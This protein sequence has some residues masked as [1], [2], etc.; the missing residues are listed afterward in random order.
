MSSLTSLT[1]WRTVMADPHWRQAEFGV[2]LITAARLRG[3]E[4]RRTE[5]CTKACNKIPWISTTVQWRSSNL[6][7]MVSIWICFDDLFEWILMRSFNCFCWPAWTLSHRQQTIVKKLPYLCHSARR[8]RKFH[9]IYG[10]RK[11]EAY[12]KGS[13]VKWVFDWLTDRTSDWLNEIEWV[14]GWN[15][16]WKIAWWITNHPRVSPVFSV[17]LLLLLLFLLLLLRCF[18]S[19]SYLFSDP[20]LLWATSSLSQILLAETFLW[21]TSSA[22]KCHAKC[23]SS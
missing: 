18:C 6:V 11:W 4:R 3:A 7:H 14:D 15:A 10:Y 5:G 16:P 23:L 2:G 19:L 17:P 20:T 13:W 12:T 8:G 22:N 9:K 21:A 1:W